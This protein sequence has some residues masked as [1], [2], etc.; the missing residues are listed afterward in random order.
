[1]WVW[2]A[3]HLYLSQY[4]SSPKSRAVVLEAASVMVLTRVG[5]G[6][7]AAAAAAAA[8]AAVPKRT[9]ASFPPHPSEMPQKHQWASLEVICPGGSLCR[10]L[11]EDRLH[12]SQHAG[13]HWADCRLGASP[14]TWDLLGLTE[15]GLVSPPFEGPQML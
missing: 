15:R 2:R 14:G 7:S 13:P 10:L 9:A 1:M 5:N 4:N 8:T 11:L 12:C 3:P 6:D